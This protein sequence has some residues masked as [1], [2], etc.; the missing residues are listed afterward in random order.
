MQDF[1]KRVLGLDELENDIAAFR[2]EVLTQFGKVLKTMALDAAAIKA[3]V[4]D[5][6][7]NLAGDVRGLKAKLEQALADQ[8]V[9]VEAAVQEALS[10]FDTLAD[11]LTALA[12]ETDEDPL[13]VDEDEEV[14][15]NA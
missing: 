10:G 8:G 11:N 5:A 12:S 14:D 3:Q 4:N 6:T 2:A 1:I 15:P 9:A 7:N 13:P